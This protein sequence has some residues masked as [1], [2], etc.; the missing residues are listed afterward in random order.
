MGE[1]KETHQKDNMQSNASS[2]SEDWVV[3]SSDNSKEAEKN[4]TSSATIDDDESRNRE[5]DISSS[6]QE[7]KENNEK[8]DEKWIVLRSGM[9][10]YNKNTRQG[11]MDYSESEPEVPFTGSCEKI[12]IANSLSDEARASTTGSS[13][14]F[15]CPNSSLGT[16]VESGNI[17][18]GDETPFTTKELDAFQIRSQHYNAEDL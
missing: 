17:N 14:I 10:H 18:A 1:K 16:N 11:Q 9:E 13:L 7:K 3:I 2:I 8:I 5:N 12:K 15:E 4:L 6:T